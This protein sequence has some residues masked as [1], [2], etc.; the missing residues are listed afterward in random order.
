MLSMNTT[1]YKILLCT[2][3]KTLCVFFSLTLK[4]KGMLSSTILSN[5][6]LS[7][8]VCA[9]SLQSSPALCD[10]MDCSLPGSSICGILQAAILEWVTMPS[11]RESFQPRD[12]THISYITY[13]GRQVPYHQRCLGSPLLPPPRKHILNISAT[14]WAALSSLFAFKP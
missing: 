9:K 6:S 3:Q 12:R 5:S 10:P 8:A 1:V 11:T 2:A 4:N 14:A 13:I 7:S